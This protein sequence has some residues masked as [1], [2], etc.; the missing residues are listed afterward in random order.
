VP[1]FDSRTSGWWIHVIEIGGSVGT[2]GGLPRCATAVAMVSAT[3]AAVRMGFI[4]ASVHYAKAVMERSDK[5][6]LIKMPP[7][8]R[9]S[10]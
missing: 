10:L 8:L 9:F 4:A 5:K 1:G 2:A 6:D 3:I 7:F